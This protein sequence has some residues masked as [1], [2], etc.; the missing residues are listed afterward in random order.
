MGKIKSTAEES[1]RLSDLLASKGQ[2]EHLIQYYT[3]QFN[4]Y[5]KLYN[6][7]LQK[8]TLGYIE[9]NSYWLGFIPITKRIVLDEQG[10]EQY[11]KELIQI[12][13]KQ[14]KDQKHLQFYLDKKT[15]IDIETD[16][17]TKECNQN[18]EVVF[19][20]AKN[21]NNPRLVSAIT[22]YNGKEQPIDPIEKIAFYKYLKQ[23]INNSLVHGKK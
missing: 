2:V 10:I 12:V 14:L 18:F 7:I 23:E 17:I 6:T 21:I 1:Q 19:E 22:D 9:T 16:R 5:Q 13:N 15:T 3:S 4:I 20:Q 8:V 11:R